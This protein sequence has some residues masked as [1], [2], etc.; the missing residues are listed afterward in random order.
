MSNKFIEKN[1]KFTLE[2]DKYIAKNPRVL[3]N[4]PSGSCVVITVKGDDDFSKRSIEIAEKTRERNQD[5]IEARKDGA[6]WIL[7][8]FAAQ[9]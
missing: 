9:K 8:S 5:C 2:F 1:I 4:V 3:K 7:R 6:N